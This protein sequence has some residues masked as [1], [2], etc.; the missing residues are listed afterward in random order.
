MTFCDHIWHGAA[1]YPELW[2]D[3]VDEDLGLMKEA[4]LDLVRVGEF[5]WS[6]MEPEEGRYDWGWLDEVFETCQAAGIGVVLCTPTP[7]PPRWMTLRYPEVLRVDAD[8]QPFQH[9]SRQHVSHTSPTYR[10]FSRQI[11]E[12]LATRYGRHPALVGWQTDNEWLCHVDG[13]HGPSAVE[14]WHAWLAER[15]GTVETLNVAWGADIWSEAYP[16]FEAVPTPRKTPFHNQAGTATGK[17]NVS[18]EMAWAL[19]TSDTVRRFQ[20]EQVAILRAHSDAPVTHNHV[21]QGRLLTED[22]FAD[23]DCAATDPYVA[24][25]DLWRTYRTMDWMRGAKMEAPGRTRPYWILET[26]P[27]FNGSVTTGHTTHPTGFLRAEA[28]VLLGM[29]GAAFCYWLWRQQR[30]GAEMCHGH[31]VTAWGTR[32]VGWENVRGV[33]EL[34]DQL[35]PIL[36]EVPPAPAALAVHEHGVSKAHLRAEPLWREFNIWSTPAEEIHR[37]LIEAGI[38]RD[39]RFESSDVTGYRAVLSPFLPVLTDDLVDRMT[40][41]VETGGTWVVGPMSGCRTEHGTVHTDAGLG[42][43]DALAGVKTLWH[44]GL[45]PVRASLGD[46]VELDVGWYAFGLEPADDACRVLGRYL[47]GPAAGA[48][49][50][51]DRPLGK[52]RIVLLAA[53]APGGYARIIETLLADLDLPRYRSSWGTTIV[54]REGDGRRA[55]IIANWDGQGGTADLPA[56]GTD[57]VGGG[58]VEAGPVRVRPFGVLGVLCD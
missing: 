41:Y 32:G 43:L 5:A 55:Y 14:A 12:A 20:A 31:V 9:G 50:A 6:R 15:Y 18:L 28:A 48:V 45:D 44:I 35:G 53:H 22:V 3:R 23:L 8:G 10:A 34:I 47:E 24:H 29:G 27:S 51:V 58:P 13:D 17:H 42:R 30:S 26:S 11:T 56:G 2:P 7:T 37:P 40:A 39:V 46:G 54:P 49:W 38:W 16:A 57:L 33:T 19:F 36:K 52:G 1:Y 25:T 4:G 21:Q